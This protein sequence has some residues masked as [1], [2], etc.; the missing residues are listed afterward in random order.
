MVNLKQLDKK[1][2]QFLLNLNFNDLKKYVDNLAKQYY[3]QLSAGEEN[4]VVTI[5]TIF[6][7]IVELHE[8]KNIES[9]INYSLIKTFNEILF[10]SVNVDSDIKPIHI[11]EP[12]VMAEGNNSNVIFVESQLEKVIRHFEEEKAFKYA[13]ELKEKLVTEDDI[14]EYFHY[15][16]YVI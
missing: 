14:K 8:D 13:D 5:I 11:N 2:T 9:Y 6:R 15:N 4:K 12:V 10:K 7:K 1:Q 16:D 3:V